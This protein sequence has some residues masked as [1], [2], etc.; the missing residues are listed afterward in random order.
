MGKF[1]ELDIVIQERRAVDKRWFPNIKEAVDM[2]NLVV[3]PMTEG[4]IGCVFD[5]SIL[6]TYAPACYAYPDNNLKYDI[7]FKEV[8]DEST[9]A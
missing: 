7:I 9:Q 6:C 1:K 3:L 4:C 5:I 8:C 2:M